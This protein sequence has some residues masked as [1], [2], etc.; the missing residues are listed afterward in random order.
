MT[1]GHAPRSTAGTAGTAAGDAAAVAQLVNRLFDI[2]GPAFKGLA[3]RIKQAVGG[4]GGGT[5]GGGTTGPGGDTTPGPTPAP[6]TQ[7]AQR[8]AGAVGSGVLGAMRGF[9]NS[10]FGG[11]VLGGMAGN[12]QQMAMM[13][14]GGGFLTNLAAGVLPQLGQAGGALAGLGP[15]GMVAGSALSLL[16]KSNAAAKERSQ[17]QAAA[18]GINDPTGGGGGMIS[19]AIGTFN[20]AA[21]RTASHVQDFSPQTV[22]L[23]T[24]AV[25]DLN[26]VFGSMLLP[27]MK[28]F[29]DVV[30]EVGA[31]LN[32]LTPVVKDL[33]KAIADAAKP[34]TSMGGGVL[35]QV[36][37]A[38]QPAIEAVTKM[39]PLI[40]KMVEPL[41]KVAG[42]VLSAAVSQ[43]GRL[44]E[45]LSGWLPKALA[46][47]GKVMDQLRPS[48]DII[49]ESLKSVMDVLG[50]TATVAFAATLK[51]V[52]A[53]FQTMTPIISVFAEQ[54]KTLAKVMELT[55]KGVQR[56]GEWFNRGAE[57]LGIGGGPKARGPLDREDN[58]GMAFQST[59]TT[60]VS[61]M[62]QRLREQ[63]FAL[64]S[65]GGEKKEDPMVQVPGLLENIEKAIN[66]LP[67]KLADA[68]AGK[69]PGVSQARDAAAG[70][71]VAGADAI[72]KL[73]NI[74][75][76]GRPGFGGW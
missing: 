33:F 19:D 67:G 42:G 21:S 34:F 31:S 59:S 9:G 36:G 56:L 29:K 71:M 27:S 10:Q 32:P 49:G 73:R 55:A 41:A 14:P 24:Q 64:G 43:V 11:Q 39:V 12:L 47:V 53:T 15:W 54:L 3:D 17:Q 62:L 38:L 51:V 63:A 25:R 45:Q 22:K 58:T 65:E 26:A 57:R 68:I 35:R 1:P 46:E 76:G 16:L 44:I 69:V 60:S 50:D 75:G 5:S 2:L 6:G 13:Q 74:F 8:A 28:M 4:K 66:N 48:F 30:R 18:G 61:S 23:Y 40:G 20:T 52:A 70:A 37:A 72:T 7:L